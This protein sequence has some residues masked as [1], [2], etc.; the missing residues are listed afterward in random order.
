MSDPRPPFVYTLLDWK[1]QERLASA[2]DFINALPK[3]EVSRCDIDCLTQFLRRFA[4]TP[5]FLLSDQRSVD[6]NVV[7]LVDM[8]FDR[9]T[10][11][12]GHIFFIPIEGEAE[13]LEEISSQK[14]S[15]DEAPLAF[16]DKKRGRIYMKLTLSPQDEEGELSR[17]LKYRTSVVEEYANSVGAM[18]IRFNRDMAEKMIAELN[19]RKRAIERAEKE[20]G[21]L[22]LP[23]IHN[24]Q[25]EETAVQ[26][27]R[28][29]ESLEANVTS[30]S[31]RQ[32]DAQ[33]QET[34]ERIRPITDGTLAHAELL[35]LQVMSLNAKPVNESTARQIILL[36]DDAI[37]EFGTTNHEKRVELERIK[38]DAEGVLPPKKFQALRERA[39]GLILKIFW[40]KQ[41]AARKVLL[42][43]VGV[44]VLGTSMFYAI[45]RL[46]DSTRFTVEPRPNSQK[47][48]P[49][50][51][52][53]A[54]NG[55]PSIPVAT[56]SFEFQTG[57]FT[58]NGSLERSTM[59]ARYFRE[60]LGDQ[61]FL[62]M[63]EIPDGKFQ[64]GSKGE[65][66]RTRETPQHEVSI[67]GFFMGRTE[68][69][70]G[71]WRAVMGSNPPNFRGDAFPVG[72]V[73]WGKAKEFCA[74]LEQK[75]GRAYR[76]PSEAEWEYSCRAG[77]TTKFA[78]GDIITPEIVN[79]DPQYPSR[80][81]DEELAFSVGSR[82]VANRFGLFD[83][84]GNVWEWCED[85]Y[86]ETYY[87]APRDGTAWISG[88][89]SQFRV[90]RGGS[91]FTDSDTCRC[92]NRYEDDRDKPNNPPSR[93]YGFRLALSK[94]Q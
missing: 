73:S 30:A 83:M 56:N 94:T 18:I 67:K 63:V 31:S 90:L 81:S 52:S 5:P 75:T 78:F 28:L 45:R 22:G 19:K 42:I 69:T 16:L 12:T 82:G 38:E 76:L 71:Q 61:V 91:W 50:P 25:H 49:V 6:E 85:V 35:Y 17:R 34:S 26:I 53:T 23:R 32:E 10:G 41:K 46:T 74:L 55:G 37:K 44:G 77:T 47:T 57:R 1:L 84:H 8:T 48:Q 15:T 60:D 9:K 2:L 93:D 4:V 72:Q 65:D 14:T 62:D 87:P 24:P 64:M 39:E 20:L 59:Q 33:S 66:V 86:H 79:Y 21:G 54:S 13:W 68:V 51:K 7:E 58:L 11:N 43:I 88:P 36:V 40:P 80:S 29:L 27:E 89:K 70:Q 92:A 3:S